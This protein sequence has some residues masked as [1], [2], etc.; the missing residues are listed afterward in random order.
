M[1]MNQADLAVK[2]GAG[3]ATVISRYENN[4]REPD[5]TVLVKL[6]EVFGCDPG[7]LLTGRTDLAMEKRMAVSEPPGV[8]Y[9]PRDPGLAMLFKKL[10]SIYNEGDRQQRAAVRGMI[11]EVYDEVRQKKPDLD[12]KE[13]EGT[14]VDRDIA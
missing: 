13:D 14:K 11:E 1:G 5:I 3:S 9:L 4:Q 6:S 10:E 2:I 8:T 7:W 12:T